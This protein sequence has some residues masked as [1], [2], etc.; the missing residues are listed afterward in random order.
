MIV[1]LRA[2]ARLVAFVLLL[3]LCLAGLGA[4][5]IA[6]TGGDPVVAGFARLPELRDAVGSFLERLETGG[7]GG[8][9]LLGGAV[10]AVAALLLLV[11]VLRKP[12][13][14]EILF[15]KAGGGHLAARRRPLAQA[16]AVLARQVRGV[17]DAKVR[18]KPKRRGTGGRI[19]VV[20][21]HPLSAD[22]G[23]VR[24][25]VAKALEALTGDSKGVRVRPRPERAGRGNRAE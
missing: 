3:V 1:L 7:G 24:E 12:L 6:V 21:V 8:A 19:D 13:P 2:V 18:I 17:T 22:P 9:A 10:V 16:A 23:Q 4:V 11:G 5:I 20:A 15:E 25:N 14:S